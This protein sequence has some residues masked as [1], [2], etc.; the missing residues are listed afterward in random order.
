[1][2]AER[3]DNRFM[4]FRLGAQLFAVPLLAVKEVIQK[5]EVTQVPNMPSHFEGMMNL[6]GQ[7]LGVYNV[8]KKLGAAARDKSELSSEVV[9]VIES[10][11]VNVGMLVDEVTRVLHAQE[12]MILPAPLKDNDPAKE[13]V[14]S[15]IKENEDL[16]LAVDAGRLLELSKYRAE[17]KA[18]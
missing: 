1:M 18:G 5:P 3:I 15:V 6:R 10:D 7:I 12:G 9:V 14:T 13:F 8:R 4:E 16:V 17:R 2:T 11:G